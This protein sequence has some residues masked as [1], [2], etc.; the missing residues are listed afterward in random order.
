MGKRKRTGEKVEVALEEAQQ[1]YG[2]RKRLD[3]EALAY[4]HEIR[5]HFDSLQEAQ[6]RTV[7]ADNCLQEAAAKP[8]QAATDAECSRIIEVLLPSASEEG[9]IAFAEG[10]LEESAWL[11]LATKWGPLVSR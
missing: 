3:S 1:G 8:L 11:T 6:E 10:L 9:L 2:F 7:I 4:F 5:S